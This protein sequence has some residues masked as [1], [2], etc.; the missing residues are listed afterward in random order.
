MYICYLDESGTANKEDTQNK[1]FVYCGFVLPDFSWKDRTQEIDYIKDKHNLFAAE[2][3]TAWLLRK[4]PEQLKID[5]F[6][7]LSYDERRQKI[8][9]LR[10]SILDKKVKNGISKQQINAQKKLYKNTD[11]YIHLTLQERVNFITEICDTM[12]QWNDARI[13]FH[14]IKKKNYDP[15]YSTSLGGMYEDAFCQIITRFQGFLE[16]IGKENKIYGLIVADNN[17]SIQNKLTLMAREFHKRGAFWR[18][19]PNIVGTPLFVDSKLTS[20]V[21]LADVAAYIIRRYYD[22]NESGLFDKL[23]PLFHHHNC[24][25]FHPL[26]HDCDCKICKGALQ[27]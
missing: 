17:T 14:A 26:E 13:F 3:H 5:N 6:D 4:Y 21:Q 11:S 15:S 25:H 1:H 22:A 18:D 19:I 2:I 20:M 12:A 7:T 10:Q 23:C 9:A 16:K 8:L 24:R 27:V